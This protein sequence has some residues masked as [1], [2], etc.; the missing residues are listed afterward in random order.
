MLDIPKLILRKLIEEEFTVAEMSKI[1]CVSEGTLF[2]R[3][4]EYDLRASA[5][6]DISNAELEQ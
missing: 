4:S 2:K 3:T 6:A 5:F 1:C